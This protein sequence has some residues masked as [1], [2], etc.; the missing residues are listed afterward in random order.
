MKDFLEDRGASGLFGSRDATRQAFE[1]ELIADG[2]IWM[3]MISSRN[4]SSHT[5][6]EEIADEIFVKILEE[7]F[8]AF[9]SFKQAMEK[10]KLG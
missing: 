9:L 7:Y 10:M 2:K 8:P 6:N 1:V 5:Y 3:D 4:K